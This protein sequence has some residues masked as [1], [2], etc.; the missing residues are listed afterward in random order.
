M[1][2]ILNTLHCTKFYTGQ[3]IGLRILELE[4]FIPKHTVLQLY[5]DPHAANLLSM[6]LQN[7]FNYF[8]TSSGYF[9]LALELHY[10]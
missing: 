10:N 1:R 5:T 6:S 2:V 7:N 4:T 3:I 8:N 9:P